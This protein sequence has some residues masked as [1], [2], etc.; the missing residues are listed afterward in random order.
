M[1]ATG[2]DVTLSYWPATTD[3]SNAA[4]TAASTKASRQATCS[5]FAGLSIHWDVHA[6]CSIA[7]QCLRLNL[8]CFLA[9]LL[10]A[11]HRHSHRA[12][13]CHGGSSAGAASQLPGRQLQGCWHRGRLPALVSCVAGMH[14]V[15]SLY[16]GAM[17][18][19]L[20]CHAMADQ[21]TAPSALLPLAAQRAK[22]AQTAPWQRH[23]MQVRLQRTP[24][25]KDRK[26]QRWAGSA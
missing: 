3:L 5:C 22:S 21:L 25:S 11:V 6:C 4:A 7:V 1:P 2:N 15:A 23:A 12:G 24:Y 16:C 18:G 26:A 10:A 19:A 17:F 20:A 14:G 13:R 9:L 8:I